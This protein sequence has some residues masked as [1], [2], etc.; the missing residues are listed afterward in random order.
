MMKKYI[1][2]FVILVIAGCDSF[3]G[4]VLRNEFPTEIEV[5]V[6]YEDGTRFSE[7]WPSCR[8]VSIGATEAGVLGAKNKGMSIEQITIK[9]G[10]IVIHNYDKVEIKKLLK[11]ADDEAGYP[12][13][14]IEPSG[15]RFSNQS[16]WSIASDEKKSG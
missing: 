6:L 8:T 13:W 14:I 4:P 9:A 7:I 11:K 15:I 2:L 16:E 12:I 1:L 5:S 10:S 3:P